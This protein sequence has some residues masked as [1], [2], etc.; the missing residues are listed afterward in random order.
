LGVLLW[1]AAALAVPSAQGVVVEGLYQGEV[2]LEAGEAGSGATAAEALRQVVVRVT[3]R[4]AAAS[5]PALSGLFGQASRFVKTVRTTAAGQVLVDFD[6][7]TLSEA[8]T[9]AGQKLWSADRPATLV[10]LLSVRPGTK[11]PGEDLRRALATA[12]QRRGVPLLFA[13]PLAAES[14]LYGELLPGRA[15]AAL[16]LARRSGAEGVLVGVLTEAATHWSWSGPAGDGVYEG[17]AAE[18]VDSLA[19]RY[20]SQ[21]AASGGSTSGYLVE[22]R[23]LGDLAA[24]VRLQTVLQVLP[25]MH[26]VRLEAIVPESN[27]VRFRIQFEGDA[28]VLSRAAVTSAG[29]GVLPTVAGVVRWE[30]RP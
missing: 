13:P 9:R 3:G 6:P 30:V 12:A 24:L 18:A 26:S 15:S 11:G 2:G 29:V 22:V 16:D 4:R 10:V 5:D 14:S 23:G 19:D 1:V 7:P 8:L 28:E 27:T 17:G 20:G 21:W 25:Q